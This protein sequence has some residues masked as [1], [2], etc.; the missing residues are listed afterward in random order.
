MCPEQVAEEE[1]G[2]E[3]EGAAPEVSGQARL[4]KIRADT[5]NT[6]ETVTAI[7]QD[8]DLQI[9]GRMM[10]EVA[11]PLR[12]EYLEVLKLHRSQ[13]GTAAWQ[14]SRAVSERALTCQRMAGTTVSWAVLKRFGLRS[15][16][17]A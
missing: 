7:M 9:S 13:R 12:D 14:A 6:L 3:A 11:L 5:S 2:E 15:S 8:R 16:E 1:P 17:G 10:V 4:A